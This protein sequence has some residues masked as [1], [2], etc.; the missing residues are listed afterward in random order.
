MDVGFDV[1][2]KA[3]V[4]LVEDVLAIPERPHLTDSLIADAGD[5]AADLPHDRINR[6]ALCLPIT[7]SERQLVADGKT[8]ASFLIGHHPLGGWLM[9][10]VVNSGANVDRWLQ[11][12]MLGDILHAL[13]VDIDLAAVAQGFAVL[14]AGADHVASPK[15]D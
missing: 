8:L 15:T 2:G 13:A 4:D 1:L 10:H 11:H 6:H 3:R 9:R 14:F 5:D 7:L 12:R